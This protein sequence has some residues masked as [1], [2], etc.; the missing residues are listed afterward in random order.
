MR[1]AHGSHRAAGRRIAFSGQSCGDAQFKASRAPGTG[2]RGTCQHKPCFQS[3][4]FSVVGT[5]RI[6]S[7]YSTLSHPAPLSVV[8]S[9]TGATRRNAQSHR[10]FGARRRST[11]IYPD[12]FSAVRSSNWSWWWSA[13]VTGENSRRA[14]PD[15][16]GNPAEHLAGAKTA[17]AYRTAGSIR[18]RHAVS[19][20]SQRVSFHHYRRTIF[21]AGVNGAQATPEPP[22]R[23]AN[24]S[25]QRGSATQQNTGTAGSISTETV[26]LPGGMRCHAAKHRHRWRHLADASRRCRERN[27]KQ[28][29]G[30]PVQFR[31]TELSIWPRAPRSQTGT[32]GSIRKRTRV[33]ANP[34]RRGG[35]QCRAILQVHLIA[36][37]A[38]YT[39]GD[40]IGSLAMS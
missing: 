8:R 27:A 35:W 39:T 31:R 22:D 25:H 9:S 11:V 37:A 23:S 33:A 38:F 18:W 16:L 12:G 34:T 5:P 4:T 1:V 13:G 15:H 29:T 40:R 32:A 6:T 7:R 36:C 26:G 2:W 20:A 24:A 17:Q 14:T 28:N 3:S 19:S 30:R 21:V 10:W